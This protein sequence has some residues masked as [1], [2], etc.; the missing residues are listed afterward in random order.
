MVNEDSGNRFP[1]IL[2]KTSD[3][4]SLY[5]NVILKC[6]QLSGDILSRSQGAR[7]DNIIPLTC[8]HDRHVQITKRNILSMS[9]GSG[10]CQLGVPLA[11]FSYRNIQ[12]IT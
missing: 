3:E 4:Y 11:N 7:T 2:N 1:G 5:K 8:Y 10:S 6:R 9:R 12:G